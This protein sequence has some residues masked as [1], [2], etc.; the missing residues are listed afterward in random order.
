MS[1]VNETDSLSQTQP[2]DEDRPKRK[3]KI[4]KYVHEL[5]KKGADQEQAIKSFNWKLILKIGKWLDSQ[6]GH[7]RGKIYH[8]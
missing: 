8:C 5:A 6:T 4:P 7:Q 2:G 1:D 3:K